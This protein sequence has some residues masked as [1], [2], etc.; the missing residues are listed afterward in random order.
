[1]RSNR[2]LK[3]LVGLFLAATLPDLAWA[4]ATFWMPTKASTTAQDVDWVFYLIYGISV[5]FFALITFLMTLFVIR[6]RRTRSRREAEASPAHNTALEV[7]WSVIP[8]IIVI[9]IFWMGFKVFLDIATPPANAYEIL[10]TG[11]RW[12]W[13][14]TYPNGHVDGTL[15]VP[16]DTPVQL[17]MTSEDVI[18]SFFVPAFRVKRDVVP[19]RYTKT[20]FEATRAGEYDIFCA[21]YCGTNHSTMLAKV[22]VHPPGDFETWLAEAS[23]FLERMSPAEAG[24]RLYISRGCAQCHSVDGR[25]GIGPTFQGVF[26]HEVVLR[27]GSR[28]LA[29]EDYLRES[30]L[31]PNAKVVAGFDPVMPTYQGRLSDREITAIIEYI[32]TLQ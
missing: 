7:T 2:I 9:G 31:E 17:V 27:D 24:E 21:E 13:E 26:S 29:D 4:K 32:K 15:H 3:T 1:V 16:V 30:I 14:F 12:S 19:G 8:T 5:F 25:P 20:W 10:V 11:Q 18:H 6:Y 28:V 23:D 22:V